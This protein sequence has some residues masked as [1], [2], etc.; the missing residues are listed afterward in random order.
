M[1]NYKGYFINRLYPSGYYE[2]YLGEGFGFV[3][4]DT[5]KGIKKEINDF[6][7]SL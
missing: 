7:N 6:I 5:L 2:T 4:A 3:K 1:I